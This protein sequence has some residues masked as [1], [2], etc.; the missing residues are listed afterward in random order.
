MN[1]KLDVKAE[2]AELPPEWLQGLDVDNLLRQKE[3]DPKKNKFGVKAGQTLE[4]WEKAGW[5]R[6]QDPRGWWQWYYR[7]YLGRR[8][9]DDGRQI[10]RWFKACGPGGRFKK[11]L[12]QNVARSGGGWDDPTVNPV[13]RQ[14]LWHWGYDLTLDD[15]RAYLPRD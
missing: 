1:R 2:L 9:R 7:F 5:T 15:Y 3:Y 12:V 8:S 6:P 11:S 10:S 4:E 14:T 13:V